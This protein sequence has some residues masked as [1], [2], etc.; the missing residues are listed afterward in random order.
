MVNTEKE[1]WEQAVKAANLKQFIG[2]GTVEAYPFKGW[3]NTCKAFVIKIPE[4]FGVA[5]TSYTFKWAWLPGTV[6]ILVSFLT[7]FIHKMKKEDVKKAWKNTGKQ[8]IGAS[9]AL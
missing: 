6:F 1:K 3:L 7:I 8:L 2:A 9:I 5:N 4:L